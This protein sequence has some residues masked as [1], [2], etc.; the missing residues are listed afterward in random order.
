MHTH[1]MMRTADFLADVYRGVV[2]R[3]FLLAHMEEAWPALRTRTLTE[4]RALNSFLSDPVIAH[5]HVLRQQVGWRIRL[6]DARLTL[7]RRLKRLLRR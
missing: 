7:R 4:G 1:N 3:D 6:A 5:W 2:D